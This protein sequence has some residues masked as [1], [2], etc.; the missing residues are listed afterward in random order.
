MSATDDMSKQRREDSQGSA[1]QRADEVASS[2]Q[3]Y[4]EANRDHIAEVNRAWRAAN[5]DR[6]RELNRLSAR[7]Q[8]ERRRQRL[9]RNAR[10]R[11]QYPKIRE[12]RV[13]RSRRFRTEHP[14]KVREYQRRYKERHPARAR[15]N[16]AAS[17]QKYRDMHAEQVREKQRQSAATRRRNNPDEYK[18]WYDAHLEEQ[19]ARGR[20]AARV[21]SRLKALGLPP[22]H[23]ERTY[24]EAK[25]A[26]NT[27]AEEFF[28]R[29]RSLDMRA[30]I[31]T[32][33]FADKDL[34]LPVNLRKRQRE[35]TR[36]DSDY[37]AA[38]RIRLATAS[39]EHR[40][41]A[42]QIIIDR[43]AQRAQAARRVQRDA[44]MEKLRHDHEQRRQAILDQRPAIFEA[45]RHRRE[46]RIR[47]D[48]RMDS[49]ARVLHGQAPYDLDTE[50]RARLDAEIA[51]I[52]RTQLEELQA[53]TLRK[54]E[55]VADRYG[56]AAPTHGAGND[57]GT[58]QTGPGPLTA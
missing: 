13:E 23:V 10:A 17:T 40:Q 53:R 24:A 47:E 3:R 55:A 57:H 28:T 54:A 37:T 48:V 26:N 14:E 19:R 42:R 44:A 15:Q 8:A 50:T 16:A 30:A 33:G 49:I 52:V 18:D 29:K 25:R 27:A 21:R 41:R 5:R 45:H 11:E 9:T 51:K 34:A 35:L 22:R 31:A 36:V 4:R 20:E 58:N 43:A 7:R 2:R 38:E 1:D 32:E 12:A 39:G 46:A 56:Y 6:V